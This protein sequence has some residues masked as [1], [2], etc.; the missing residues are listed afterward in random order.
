MRSDHA[1]ETAAEL[2]FLTGASAEQLQRLLPGEHPQVIAVA[3]SHISSDRAAL[4]LGYLPPETQVEVARR[5]AEGHRAPSELVSEIDRELARGAA[6]EPPQEVKL[7]PKA[8]ANL[9]SLIDRSVERTVLEN[10]EPELAEAVRK[11]M[12]V[13]EDLPKLAERDL[14]VVL[15]NAGSQ[16][17]ALALKS[18]EEALQEVIFRNISERVAA[19]V[20]EDME[21]QQ[22]VRPRE[23]EAAQQRISVIVRDMIN[24]GQISLVEEEGGR[25]L[26]PTG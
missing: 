10:L 14:Q 18:A 22:R 8:L 11:G 3:L 4:V 26:E 25:D 17:L 12:F 1:Q 5:I 7:G 21:L 20:K 13:F 9:L 16:D 2:R 23:I 19:A 6:V 24:S 15:Q